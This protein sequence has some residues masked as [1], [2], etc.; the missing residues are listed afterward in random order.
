MK[1]IL[2]LLI[3]LALTAS[4]SQVAFGYNS[5]TAETV[6]VVVDEDFN[7]YPAGDIKGTLGWSDGYG[8]DYTLTAVQ[9][10][11]NTYVEIHSVGLSGAHYNFDNPVDAGWSG[12]G[13]PYRMWVYSARMK[14]SEAEGYHNFGFWAPQVSEIEFRKSG[15]HYQLRP[16]DG[17]TG[18]TLEFPIDQWFDFEMVEYATY[19]DGHHW[20]KSISCDGVTEEFNKEVMQ[21]NDSDIFKTLRFF[22]W[23][24]GMT[25]SLDSIK[26]EYVVDGPDNDYLAY[27]SEYTPFGTVTGNNA[28][29]RVEADEDVNNTYSVWYDFQAADSGNLT[30]T[31]AGSWDAYQND[32]KIAVYSATTPTPTYA[33]LTVVVP[34]TDSGRDESVSFVKEAGKYYFVAVCSYEGAGNFTLSSYDG[35]LYVAPGGTGNGFTE[36]TPMGSIAT[37]FGMIQP[38]F[39]VHLAPGEYSI[40]DNFNQTDVWG[41]GMTVLCFKTTGVTLQGAGPDK[42]TIVVPAGYVGVRMEKDGCSI[43]DLTVRAYRTDNMTYHYNWHMQGA[44]CACNCSDMSVSNVAI[45]SEQKTNEIRPFSTYSTTRLTV[46]RLAVE[47]P[48]CGSPVFVNKCFDLV[49]NK[50]TVSGKFDGQNPGVYVGNWPWRDGNLNLTFNNILIANVDMPFTVEANDEVAVNNSVFYNCTENTKLFDGA[51][52][53]ENGCASYEYGVNDPELSEVD[54]YILTSS[55]ATYNNIGWHTVPEPA[56]FGLLA[57]VAL[58]LRRK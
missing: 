9:D 56:V 51:V 43:R 57:I 47:A 6:A 3:A 5:D 53:N 30:L 18:S 28:F 2:F 39:T 33:D 46:D 34:L 41:A 12:A 10:G 13:N 44:I 16:T 20:L 24:G 15:D 38:G 49:V 45:Y 19:T 36:E 26:I 52:Y 23:A 50:M 22:F 4:L 1:K 14:L 48:D 17:E 55:K 42:T 25:V 11:D 7:D 21:N 40:A 54:G 31:T 8:S 29:A 37:A 58:F 32:T 35:N 27:S